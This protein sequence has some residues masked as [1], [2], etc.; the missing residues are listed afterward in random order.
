M[1]KLLTSFLIAL[2]ILSVAIPCHAISGTVTLANIRLSLVNGTAFV[3]FSS[4]G[5]LTF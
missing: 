1:K 4:A 5:T 2:C 3:D